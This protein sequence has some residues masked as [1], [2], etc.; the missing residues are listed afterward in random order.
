MELSMLVARNLARLTTIGCLAFSL[1]SPAQ[2]PQLPSLTPKRPTTPVPLPPAN[3]ATPPSLTSQDVT[4]FLD[5][6]LPLQLQ[7]VDVAGATIAITQNGQPLILKGYG[8]ADWKKKTPVDP[9]TTTFRPGSISKLFTYVSMMQLVEQGKLD[10]DTDVSRYLDFPINPG[11]SG[12]GNAPITLRNLATHTAGFEE[13]DHDFG[14]DKSGKLPY[15]LRDYLLRNQPNRFAA[16]GK[17]LAYSNY[18]IAMIG[19]IIQ[20][21]SGEPF[22]GYVQQHIFTPLGMTH[23]TFV[24]PLPAGLSATLGYK[25]TEASDTGFEGVTAVPAGGLSSTAADMALFGQMLLNHGTLNRASNSVKILE[26]S[27]IA[28]LFTPQFTPAPGVAPWNL[29]F[30]TERRNGIDFIGHGGDLIACHSRLWLDPTHN[31]VLFVS[32]NSAKSAGIAREELFRAFVDRYLPG[33]AVH[34]PYRKL[35]AKELAPYTGNYLSSRRADS[36]K[37]RLF[38]LSDIRKINATKDGDLTISSARDFHGHLLHF[39]PVGNDSFYEEESQNTLHFERAA[40]GQVNGLANPSHS[41][42]VPLPEHPPVFGI[43][44]NLSL[45]AILAAC[46]APILRSFRRIF[47]PHRPAIAPQ[48]GTIWLTRPLQL[49]AFAILAVAAYA[50][51]LIKHFADISN[52]YQ[53]GHLDN[54]FTLQNI[55]TLL[56]L[57][58]ILAGIISGIKTLRRQ[59]RFITKLKF[60][61]VT[62]ACLYCSWFF[63]YFHFIGSAHH[64]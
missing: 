41:D 40:N 63:L 60:A 24:Q 34:P 43:L 27:S 6:F 1:S 32:Y 9:V 25:S 8:Y 7:R 58:A 37:F 62:L 10:L 55:L 53:I 38:G 56:A 29:G 5:G 3:P 16:P 48:P 50:I 46:I 18:G 14:S 47:Q 30:Y 31:L 4:T 11:P 49:A 12:I 26:P 54:Y 35:S 64:Y 19:Y 15:S 42:R 44:A 45:L 13:T 57:V 59:L 20:R 39:H 21:V 17:A 23:S 33:P 51:F 61:L 28:T 52:F 22:A 2:A 36:T